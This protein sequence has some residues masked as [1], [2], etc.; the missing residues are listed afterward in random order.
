[1]MKGRIEISRRVANS[2]VLKGEDRTSFETRVEGIIV[3]LAT[4]DLCWCT[5][6]WYHVTAANSMWSTCVNSRACWDYVIKENNNNLD[7]Y[8]SVTQM[9]D[10]RDWVTAFRLD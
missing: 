1:M 4:G 8:V 5:F 10:S 9:C 3:K 6:V 7:A 2:S